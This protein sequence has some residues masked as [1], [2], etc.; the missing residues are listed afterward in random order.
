MV[1]LNDGAGARIQEGP[2]S[3]ASYGGS[4]VNVSSSGVIPQISVILG[5]CATT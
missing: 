3:L 1:G 2:V 5:P 4:S